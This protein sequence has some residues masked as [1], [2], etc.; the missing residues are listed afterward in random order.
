LRGVRH[1]DRDLRLNGGGRRFDAYMVKRGECNRWLWRQLSLEHPRLCGWAPRG[2]AFPWEYRAAQSHQ[3]CPDHRRHRNRTG[4]LPRLHFEPCCD[5]SHGQAGQ[6]APLLVGGRGCHFFSEV[7]GDD[8]VLCRCGLGGH[9]LG[10]LERILEREGV[11]V[12][13]HR[14]GAC[15]IEVVERECL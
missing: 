12:A 5:A 6:A 11:L 9:R 7:G 14:G 13:D 2:L 1:G 3:A 15:S 8:E 10:R 4:S